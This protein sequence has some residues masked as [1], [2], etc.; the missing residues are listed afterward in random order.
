IRMRLR[1]GNYRFWGAHAYA[2]VRLKRR[3]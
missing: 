2:P 1:Q 3:A